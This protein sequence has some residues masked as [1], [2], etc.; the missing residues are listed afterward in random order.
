[1]IYLHKFLPI[2]ISPIFLF[3]M[4]IAYG[5]ILEKKRPII[6]SVILLYFFSTPLVSDRIF[7]LIENSIQQP[8]IEEIS[9]TEAIVV[10]SGMVSFVRSGTAK[11]HE[12]K[13]P[14]R[15]FGG[16]DLFKKNKANFLIFTEARLPWTKSNVAEGTYLKKKAINMGINASNILVTEEVQNT[17]QEA[18]KVSKILKNKNRNIILVTSAF[19]MPRAKSLFEEEGFRVI[20]FPVDFKVSEKS[21]TIMDF[22]PLS[23]GLEKTS[24][25]SRE[26]IG[27][28]YYKVLSWF[29][30][31]G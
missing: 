15:F 30:I 8:K 26:L 19:H 4:G 27:R 22:F 12:W 31:F 2:L 17:K 21:T 1:M 28:I 5:L 11:I 10:L 29:G 7:Y 6:I 24:A 13:D 16:I 20:P 23:S 18:Q 9:K 14:D 3:I 25:A